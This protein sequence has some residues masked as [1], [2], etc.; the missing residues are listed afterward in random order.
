MNVICNKK[1]LLYTLFIIFTWNLLKTVKHNIR[2]VLK[3]FCLV[4]KTWHLRIIYE[5]W[6]CTL[7]N[8]LKR[9]IFI[10][11]G[12]NIIG[13]YYLFNTL[14]LLN[15]YYK[16]WKCVCFRKIHGGSSLRIIKIGESVVHHG[17]RAHDNIICLF[18][19]ELS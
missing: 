14:Q 8:I 3:T 18:K 1:T 19:R 6:L 13:I 11:S 16:L 4:L 5:L 9:I 2:V 10:C 17:Y 15:V 12:C 7:S